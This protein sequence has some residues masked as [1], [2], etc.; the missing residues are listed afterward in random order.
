MSPDAV[1]DALWPEVDPAKS[2]NSA[3]VHARYLRKALEAATAEVPIAAGRYAI[4]VARDQIDVTRFEDLSAAAHRASAAGDPHRATALFAVALA[5]WRG[6]PYEDFPE[7]DA[8]RDESARLARIRLDTVEAYAS[9]LLDDDSPDEACRLLHPVVDEHLTHETLAARLMLAFYRT[10]RP[11]DALALLGRVKEALAESG[12]IPS[13]QLT[14]LANAIVTR[15]S[16][17]DVVGQ[18]QRSIRTTF[19]PRQRSGFIGRATELLALNTAWDNATAGVPQLSIVAG[20]TGIGKSALVH[21]FI[22]D[23]RSNGG[24]VA[25]GRCDP[26]PG[27]NFEPFPD[28]VRSVIA[29]TPPADSEPNV[30]RELGR[31]APDL[32]ET[33]PPAGPDAE[34]A[35]GRQRFFGAV[36]NVLTIPPSPRLIVIENL[37][38][39]RPDAL[40]M[41]RHVMR[42]ASGQIMVMCTYRDRRSNRRTPA[43]PVPFTGRLAHPDLRI[44]LAPMNHHEV[45][46]IVDSL[47]PVDLRSAWID[48]LDELVAVSRGNPLAIREV[49]RQLERDPNVPVAD[50]APDD[51]SDLVTRRLH[52]LDE[53]TRAVLEIGAVMGRQFSLQPVAIAAGLIETDALAALEPAMEAGM[54]VDGNAVDDFEFAHPL[55]RNTVYKNL[56]ASRRARSHGAIGESL[57]ATFDRDHIGGRWAEVA[58]HLVAAGRAVDTAKTARF[59]QRAGDDAANRYAHED[60]ATWYRVAVECSVRAAAPDHDVARLRLALGV[61]LELS[62]QLDAART[63]YFVAADAARTTGDTALLIDAAVAATPRYAVLDR[64]FAPRL[65]DLADE[66]LALLPPDDPAR[67]RL[68]R[69]AAYARY[70]YDPDSVDGYALEA[71]RLSTL[72]ADPEIRGWALGL[73]YL[74]SAN[75]DDQRLVLSSELLRH[76]RHHN[77]AGHRGDDARRFLIDQL[78]HGRME[79]FD[80]EIDAMSHLARSTSNPFDQYWVAALTA[81]RALMQAASSTT[82]ALI[83]AAAV[84]GRQL[85]VFDTTGLH[86]LQTFALRY[87]QGRARE[88]TAGLSGG[89]IDAPPVIAGTS[90]LALAFAEGERLDPARRALERVVDRRGILLPRDNFWLGGVALFSGVAAACGTTSQRHILRTNLEPRADRFCVFGAGGAVFG[91]GHHWLARLAAADGNPQAAIDHL[92][93]AANICH[94]AGATFWEVRAHREASELTEGGRST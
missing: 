10:G 90:L 88:V 92:A 76:S 52:T 41:L 32:S 74:A 85:Q 14:E 30:L 71:G 66:A 8:L 2:I 29:T 19:Q 40:S 78:I 17:L 15:D 38:W 87:Q 22:E 25:V 57:A 59:A 48:Q 84:L 4:T 91:T 42:A 86:M 7:V 55:Y 62:G 16:A 39:A 63:E 43:G 9:S 70:G 5:E 56:P 94:D 13:H 82:E 44:D 89:A 80:T 60:A 93:Q 67:V 64:D 51:M 35:A 1:A 45:A 46:A 73:R 31:L 68:L 72:T 75:D 11:S 26:D 50:L 27:E 65:A 23:V 20:V 33:L 12:L 58:R 21:R 83:D 53:T 61:E 54:I 24:T 81:T 28:L 6:E 47:A 37:H 3:R 69:S 18:R 79:E 77:L 36:A 49:L 34:P